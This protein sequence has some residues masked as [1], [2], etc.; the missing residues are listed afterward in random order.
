MLRLNRGS[1]VAGLAGV[2]PQGR[3]RDTRVR[4]IRPLL[5]FRRAELR[6]VVVGAGLSAVEDPSNAN[7]RFD[8]VRLRKALADAEWL[9]PS[10]LAASAAYLADADD[11]LEWATDREWDEQVVVSAG[12]VRYRCRAP[13]AV[14]LRI[15]ERA[16]VALGGR[17]RGQDVARLLDRLEYE[18]EGGNL[19][20]VLVTAEGDQWAFR[21]EPAR[22]TR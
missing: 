11:A 6:K 15:A 3:L 16:I 21:R 2:R 14:A 4:L 9:E 20:G 8:R 7:E 1:G 13:R 22:R 17:P 19:A 12:E 10:W 5:D 18:G